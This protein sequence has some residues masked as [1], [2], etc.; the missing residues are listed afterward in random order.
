VEP[1]WITFSPDGSRAYVSNQVSGTVSVIAT[2]SGAVVATI[3]GFSCPFH[4][5]ITHDGETLLVSSQCNGSLMFVNLSTNTV[6]KSIF[7]GDIPRGIA[8]TPDGKRTYVTNDGS[9]LVQV[10]DVASEANLNTPITVGS[11]PFGIAMTPNGIAYVA[12]FSDGTISVIDTSTNAVTA[13][14]KAPSVSRARCG[15]HDG[16]AAH[17]QLFFPILRSS[18]FEGYSNDWGQQ[19]RPDGRP[20]PGRW[21]NSPRFPAQTK[22]LGEGCGA[23]HDKFSRARVCPDGRR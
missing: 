2:A 10:I 7:V 3:G 4:S 1:I 17:P 6:V 15:E 13:T 12:N 22:R 9:N 20:I 11:N 19:S 18:R 14:L 16:E 23:V 8:L 5:K 21:G